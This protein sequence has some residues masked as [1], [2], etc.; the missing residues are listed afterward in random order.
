MIPF[1]GRLLL[2]ALILLTFIL[3]VGMITVAMM[4]WPE[5]ACISFVAIIV[6]IGG[7]LIGELLLK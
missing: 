2:G 6:L 1:L 5:A 3:F 4:R 7:G